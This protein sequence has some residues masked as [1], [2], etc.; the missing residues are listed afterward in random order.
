MKKLYSLLSALLL[1]FCF[2]GSSAA[3]DVFLV[4]HFE[5]QKGMP[6]PS[7]TDLGL[8]RAG[9]LAKILQGEDIQHIYSTDYNRTQQTATPFSKLTEAPIKSYSPKA[10]A[11]FAASI[12]AMKQSALIVGHSN[13]TPMMIHLLGGQADSIDES[14]Y[15][16]LYK[17]SLEGDQVS[18]TIIEVP[19]VE[20]LNTEA[21]S[22]LNH[23]P[24]QNKLR[25]LFHDNE[26]GTALYSYS[27]IGEMIVAS[28][29]TIIPSM[30]IDAVVKTKFHG[31][32]LTTDFVKITGSMG[33]EVD[34]DVRYENE[35]V[36][37]HSLMTR[38]PFKPVGRMV[39]DQTL[40]EHAYD[41]ATILMNIASIKYTPQKQY[42]YWFNSYDNE[43][44]KISIQKVKQAE[45]SVP[46]GTFLTDV[47]EVTGGAPSQVYYIDPNTH[48]TIKIEIPGMPWK[49]E[50]VSL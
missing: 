4:R 39:I 38:Q 16:V 13:T 37:G 33:Q 14:E 11:E 12:K 10:L 29:H 7:L 34:I 23:L 44:K 3:F 20:K 28:E 25:M 36:S 2:S 27:R 6:D 26:V 17:L 1:S 9:E 30:N 18:Q 8:K 15:G 35:Q 49:Y 5:K 50:K 48:S 24:A 41:R 22:A 19:P 43:V 46:A 47:V 42:F 21:L 32:K 45:I 31:Q 40:P